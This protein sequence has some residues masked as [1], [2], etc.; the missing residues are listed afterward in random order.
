[1]LKNDGIIYG[2]MPY[3]LHFCNGYN[4]QGNCGFICNVQTI[5]S[6]SLTFSLD[7]SSHFTEIKFLICCISIA[8]FE[9]TYVPP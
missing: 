5:R 7:M 9:G 4:I 6:V 8:C 2:A 3:S 1:M